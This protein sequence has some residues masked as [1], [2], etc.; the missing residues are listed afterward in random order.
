M[1]VN[2]CSTAPDFNRNNTKDPKSEYFVP[3]LPENSPVSIA[4]D[5]SRNV[6]LNWEL[7]ELQ[8]GAII[9]KKYHPDSPF[10]ALDTLYSLNS[11]YIDSSGHF[12]PGTAYKVDFF[13]LMSDSSM[14]L[15]REAAEVSMEFDSFDDIYL[16]YDRGL[17]ISYNYSNRTQ[18]GVFQYFDGVEVLINTSGNFESPTWDT[19]GVVSQDQFEQRNAKTNFLFKLF[20]L[21][22]KVNQFIADSAGRRI[23]LSSETQRFYINSVSNVSFEFID[24]LSGTVHWKNNVS[25]AD[26]FIIESNKIDTIYGASINSYQLNFEEPLP[27]SLKVSISPFIGNNTGKKQVPNYQRYLE[28]Y[29]PLITFY[30]VDD[31]SFEI[32]WSVSEDNQAAGY[33]I[34]QSELPEN[35]FTPIDTVSAD[36][37]SYIVSGLDR[38]TNYKFAVRSY[39]SDRSNVLSVGYQKTFLT[40]EPV[41]LDIPG[42]NITYSK[43]GKYMAKVV[44][45][46]FADNYQYIYIK[47]QDTEAEYTLELP[48][49]RDDWNAVFNGFVVSEKNNTLIFLWDRDYVDAGYNYISVYDFI[50]NRYFI[51]YK[52]RPGY[53][54]NEIEL[55]SDDERVVLSSSEGFTIF[56]P[57]QDQIVREISTSNNHLAT[58]RP[59]KD[60]AIKCSGSGIFEYD[61]T[62]GVMINQVSE[63]CRYATINESSN[64][65]TFFDYNQIK[66]LD[67]NTF[68]VI[69]TINDSRIDKND[70]FF[71][72][73]YFEEDD[74]LIYYSYSGIYHGI[75]VDSEM[76][77]AFILPSYT[78]NRPTG[79]IEHMVRESNGTY[80]VIT[81]DGAFTLSYEETWSLIE[82]ER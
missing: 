65:L 49:A 23:P 44:P 76:K 67:L 27:S 81:L 24:E 14:V 82:N 33:I 62:S 35:E 78:E 72:L 51:Q 11:S 12:M 38:N 77:F 46:E 61:L 3:E 31:N 43:N 75:E 39:T 58:L 32:H 21:H 53:G 4:L 6:M 80:S 63:P 34:E 73:W 5:E 64:L 54:G 52:P 37:R 36:H 45:R 74:L 26:G 29:T 47:D 2:N 13:R 68:T 71:D 50:N 48:R 16:Y 15:N 40:N 41:Q 69:K 55:M 60:T 10:T 20:D 8:D 19:I 42:T 28:V 22:I 57:T 59:Y 7:K 30:S 66:V 18:E 9:S 17:E 25:F 79:Y 70:S 56:D 1:F